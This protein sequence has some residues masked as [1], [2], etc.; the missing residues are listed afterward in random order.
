LPAGK[1]Q[2]ANAEEG[3]KM[4]YPIYCS[5]GT[6]PVITRARTAFRFVFC[7]VGV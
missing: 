5:V 1:E 7:G 6:L 3:G 4:R 2:K